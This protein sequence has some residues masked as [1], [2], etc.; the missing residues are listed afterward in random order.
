MTYVPGFLPTTTAFKFGN[1]WPHLPLIT[2]PTPFGTINIGD[3]AMGVCGG[4][5]YVARDLFESRALPPTQNTP[6]DNTSD[7]ICQFTVGRFLD[8]MSPAAVTTYYALMDP[9]LPD[10]ETDLSKIGLAPHGRAWVMINDAWP[11]IKADIDSGHPSPIGLVLI[12]SLNPIDLGHNHVVLVFGYDLIGTDL[13]L[14]VYDCNR[15][16]R[17]DR[18]IR[19]S[20]ADPD[21]TTAVQSDYSGLNCFFHLDDYRAVAPWQRA[22]CVS[23]SVPSSPLAAG[24]SYPVSITMR[25]TGITTWTFAGSNPQRLGSQDP[26]DNTV[27]GLNRVNVPQ[28]VPP[29]ASAVFNFNITAPLAAGTRPFQWRMV[30]EGITWFGDFTPA[31]DYAVHLPTLT[32]SIQPFPAVLGQSRSYTVQVQDADSHQ[33][34]NAAVLVNGVQVAQSNVPFTY[35]FI[36]RTVRVYDPKTR[37]WDVEEVPPT[38]AVT[39]PGYASVKVNI[40]ITA[41]VAAA[42]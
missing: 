27:W 25:N 13:T 20:I 35:T 40:G 1:S 10:H 33:L 11:K 4:M 32:A 38:V 36:L 19:L 42:A 39:A 17:D 34:V 29:T 28:I 24:R 31:I 7:P 18:T 2:I 6:P 26:Q 16:L 22:V 3:T 8:S 41:E 37:T 12:K 9:A 23:Q 15:P 5:A 21:H 30:Q 14:H